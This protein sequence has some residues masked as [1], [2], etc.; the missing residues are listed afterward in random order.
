MGKLAGSLMKKFSV[1][2]AKGFGTISYHGISF[3][4]RWCYSTKN[5]WKRCCKSRKRNQLVIGN[6]DMNEII[7]IINPLENPVVLIDG[8]SETVKHE[9]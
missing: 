7:K 8:V 3:C 9:I 6:E 2:L 1:R 5:V 4:N